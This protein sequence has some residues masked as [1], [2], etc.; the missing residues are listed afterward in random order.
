MPTRAAGTVARSQR[1]VAISAALIGLLVALTVPAGFGVVAYRDQVRIAE[2]RARLSAERVGQFA[3]VHGPTW[4]YSWHRM[5]ELIS[6]VNTDGL[7]HQTVTDEKGETLATLGELPARPRLGA[8]AP[9][10]SGGERIGTVEVEISL[11]PFLLQLAVLTA[12]GLL[13]GLGTYGCAYAV[14]MRAL[15]RA[16][17]DLVAIE[18]QLREQVA[19]TEAALAISMEERRRAEDASRTKS[20]FLANISHELRTPLNAII[21]FSDAMR[22]QFFGPLAE[23]Y[24][25]YSEDIHGSGEHLLRLIEE[26]LDIAKIESGHLELHREHVD[27]HA[28]LAVCARLT[29]L[30]AEMLGITVR[31]ET[32][33]NLPTTLS[34]DPIRTRQI[35]LNL[36]SNAIKFTPRGGSVTLEARR[37]D[38]AGVEIAVSDTGIGM[39]A[40][41]VA[42]ALQPFR[43]IDN[44]YTRQHGGTGLGLP[45]AKSLTEAH[46]GTLAIE[47]LPGRGTRVVV[48]MPIGQP[49][50]RPDFARALVRQG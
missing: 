22:M 20:D 5:P 21:G 43:Q 48:R 36:L 1:V 29:G 31:L 30:R 32:D 38:D 50:E 39:T 42:V 19:Q 35:V 13:L 4:R 47:S 9:I 44:A 24:R 37:T 28:L 10:V 25:A 23:R 2:F 11:L 41:Q 26:L 15:R 33:P 14:P 40:E 45:I 17:E 18:T 16:T 46:G 27:L 34:L 7:V 49:P 6:F 8:A 3:Y 12:L